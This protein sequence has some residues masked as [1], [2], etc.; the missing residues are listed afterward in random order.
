MSQWLFSREEFLHAASMEDGFAETL[1]QEKILR[2]RAIRTVFDIG[3]ELKLPQSTISTA[4]SYLHRFYTRKSFRDF[5]F[6][7]CNRELHSPRHS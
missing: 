1:H 2:G 5:S 6:Y 3:I 7:V 4:C